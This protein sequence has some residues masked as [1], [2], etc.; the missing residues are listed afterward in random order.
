[1]FEPG[2]SP[3][4]A[5]FWDVGWLYTWDLEMLTHFPIDT[6]CIINFCWVFLFIYPLSVPWHSSQSKLW[7]RAPCSWHRRVTKHSGEQ[8]Q[9]GA[10]VWSLLPPGSHHG[11][12]PHIGLCR[13]LHSAEPGQTSHVIE[14]SSVTA[15]LKFKPYWRIIDIQNCKV[16]KVYVMIWYTYILWKDSHVHHHVHLS[17]F[18]F[19]MRTFT[20]YFLSR[21]PFC[22]FIVHSALE[23]REPN[24][25]R[26]IKAC[27][28]HGSLS[29]IVESCWR[30]KVLTSS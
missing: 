20:F 30:W 12:P 5:L 10:R 13:F 22:P 18:L 4:A 19:F 16:F 29:S 14:T 7:W 1:M 17:L 9:R 6:S 3:E 25:L 23:G 27:W 11:A 21:F 24:N 26:V 28:S 2:L 15:L 8:Q